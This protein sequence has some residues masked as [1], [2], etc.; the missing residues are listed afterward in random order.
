M[1]SVPLAIPQE[2][3]DAWPVPNY[4]D[5]VSRGNSFY[6]VSTISVFA[7][8]VSVCLR[9]WTR[10]HL[11]RYFGLDD[12][13]IILALVRIGSPML[14]NFP[15][16]STDLLLL[17]SFSPSA[18]LLPYPSQHTIM[19]GINIFGTSHSN[20]SPVSFPLLLPTYTYWHMF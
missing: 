3:F 7:A 6:Y 14:S 10:I 18:S 1:F 12:L 19:D 16:P 13:L 4:I 9:L 5:P 15:L 17:D 11:R 8:T 20:M 2:V